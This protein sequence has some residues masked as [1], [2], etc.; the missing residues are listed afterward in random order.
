MGGLQKH[1]G[2]A[3]LQMI[4]QRPV[5]TGTMRVKQIACLKPYRLY[6]L[7]YLRIG[8]SGATD[9]RRYIRM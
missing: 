5:A 4:L 2:L 8:I 3:R 7:T 6:R 9:L 1:S